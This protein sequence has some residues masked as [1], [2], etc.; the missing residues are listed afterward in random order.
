M[1]E[2]NDN[3]LPIWFWI[4][5]VVALVWNLLGA[6]AFVM[7]LTM[8]DEAKAQLPELEQAM[9]ASAP[10]WYMPAFC[11]A[12]MAGVLGCVCLLLRK[13]F[14]LTLF[15]MSMVGIIAQQI[16][17]FVLSDIGKSMNGGQLGMTLSIPVVGVLLI[18]FARSSVA[19]NWLR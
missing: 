6:M 14:A 5:S 8:S 15:L 9:Y 12:A 18:W 4:V 11:F 3:K 2:A 19:K 13:R 7:Q 1:S 16:Y 10:S 17:M